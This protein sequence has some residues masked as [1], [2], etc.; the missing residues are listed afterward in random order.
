MNEPY[1]NQLTKVFETLNTLEEHINQNTVQIEQDEIMFGYS[2][3]STNSNV[4][5][6]M[7]RE[8]EATSKYPST[9]TPLPY[10]I[11]PDSYFTER[12]RPR[13]NAERRKR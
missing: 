6:K 4:S 8:E 2:S 5:I 11:R 1:I 7:E 3:D 13:S 12:V 9:S 10:Q